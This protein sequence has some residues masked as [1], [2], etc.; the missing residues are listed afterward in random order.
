MG[1]QTEAA[2]A[3]SDGF[4]AGSK[5]A[6]LQVAAE[7]NAV[8]AAVLGGN[9]RRYRIATNL[10]VNHAAK[11]RLFFQIDRKRVSIT[12]YLLFP[13]MFPPYFDNSLTLLQR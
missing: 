10:Y 6:A 12:P 7:L 4:I 1:A 13:T 11:I 2:G 5:S 8:G 3:V 9:G